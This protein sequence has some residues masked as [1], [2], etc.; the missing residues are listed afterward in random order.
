M[1]FRKDTTTPEL[2][3]AANL[4]GAVV[5]GLVE[6]STLVVVFRAQ[7]LIAL[8]LYGLSYAVRRGG[9]RPPNAYPR[10]REWG[11]ASGRATGAAGFSAGLHT[12]GGL[13]PAGRKSREW[14]GMGRRAARQ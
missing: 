2:A 3:F 14:A 4:L 1:L 12:D 9:N 6:Y 7:L 8:A 10:R 11:T 13:T 5:G